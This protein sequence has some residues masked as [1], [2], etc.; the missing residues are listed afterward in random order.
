M[1]A[2]TGWTMSTDTPSGT[3][4]RIDRWVRGIADRWVAGAT[5]RWAGRDPTTPVRGW[6]SDVDDR[7]RR[8]TVAVWAAALLCYGLGDTG[9]TTVVLALGGFEVNPVARAF[10]AQLGYPG[11]AVQKG[12]VVAVL[13]GVWRHYPTVGGLSADPW[14][15]V[16]P[17]VAAVRGV[18]L[19]V[20]HVSNVTA[21]V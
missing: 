2:D 11:L 7:Y 10:I 20:I 4:S 14:R 5:E 15:L 9:L 21:L 16:V 6:Y 13:A 17:A 18:Q 1:V 3:D 8:A 12:L 19:V